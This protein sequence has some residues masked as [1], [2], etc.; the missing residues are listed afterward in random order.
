MNF[1]NI[2]VT[3]TFGKHIPTFRT[4]IERMRKN[5]S[6]DHYL[7]SGFIKSMK[8][9]SLKEILAVADKFMFFP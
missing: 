3:L 4:Q 2:Y 9:P 1:G 5:G 7:R 6:I 8:T